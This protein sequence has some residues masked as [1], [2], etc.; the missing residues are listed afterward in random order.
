M[1]VADVLGIGAWFTALFDNLVCW[2]KTAGVEL[3][4]LLIVGI[5]SIWSSAVGLLPGMPDQPTLPGSVDTAFGFAR[6]AVPW[7][8][9]VTLFEADVA[10]L[11]A[12]F[13]AAALLRWVKVVE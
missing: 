4:N 2:I 9:L 5:G 1:T 7:D 6:W 3:L 13:V 8:Y 12:W 10:I 11:L